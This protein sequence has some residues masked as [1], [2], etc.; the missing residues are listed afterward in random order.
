MR[1]ITVV[2][3]EEADCLTLAFHRFVELHGHTLCDG[4]RRCGLKT[5]PSRARDRCET[6]AIRLWSPRAAAE[7]DRFWT[8][9]CRVYAGKA[10]PPLR[11]AA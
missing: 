10:A 3:G 5:L 4:G 7:F 8:A 6:K 9:Y 2:K 11:R 1:F